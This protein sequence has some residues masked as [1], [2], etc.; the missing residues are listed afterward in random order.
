MVFCVR[1][2]MAAA[3]RGE[4]S[5]YW[6]RIERVAAIPKEE[7]PMTVL[8]VNACLRGEASRTLKLCREYLDGI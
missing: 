1:W 5:L 7:P 8:F 2:Q 6:V 4:A 3:R